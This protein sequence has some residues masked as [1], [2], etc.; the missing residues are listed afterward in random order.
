MPSAA[1][2]LALH[3]GQRRI[4]PG[5]PADLAVVEPDPLMISPVDLPGVRAVATV[6]AGRVVWLESDFRDS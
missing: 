2:A 4:A 1:E 3:S 6:V 5:M